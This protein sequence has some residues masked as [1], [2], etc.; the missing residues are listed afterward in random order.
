[1]A[2]VNK[3]FILGSVGQAP[4]VRYTSSGVATVNLSVATNRSWVKKGSQEK[5]EEVEWHRCVLWDKLA[6]VCGEYVHKGDSV[7]LE[8]RLKTRSWD[9]NGTKK[10]TT[11]IVVES[12]NMLGRREKS[13]DGSLTGRQRDSTKPLSKPQAKEADRIVDDGDIPF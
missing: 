1:M 9:D 8:G 7:H 6:E 11:E 13:A 4:E 5:T 2:S 12:L 10:F 3:V